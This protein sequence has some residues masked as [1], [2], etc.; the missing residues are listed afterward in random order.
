[1][2]V[3]VRSQSDRVTVTA[4]EGTAGRGPD[5]GRDLQREH[6]ART[7]KS[8]WREGTQRDGTFDGKTVGGFPECSASLP[9]PPAR[10]F[11]TLQP[12]RRIGFRYRRCSSVPTR[13]STAP[14][15]VRDPLTTAGAA[16]QVPTSFQT[17]PPLNLIPGN[18]CTSPLRNIGAVSS[19]KRLGGLAVPP[20]PCKYKVDE[21]LTANSGAT[22]GGGPLGLGAVESFSQP[23][24]RAN[25]SWV[26]KQRAR[27]EGLRAFPLSSAH[28]LPPGY[29]G[30][31]RD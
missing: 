7:I 18:P 10:R 26:T 21:A 3:E 5:S 4:T 23:V 24:R 6:V 13:K 17:L 16:V 25:E 27:S 31:T 15:A 22:V 29:R 8:S 12:V 19:R 2:R 9:T 11:C 1:M 28:E 20:L 30:W 14:S